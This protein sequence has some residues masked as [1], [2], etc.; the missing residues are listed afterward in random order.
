[1]DLHELVLHMLHDELDCH[2]VLASSR[3]D[4]VSILHG[5][6]NELMEGLQEEQSA[7]V[8]IATAGSVEYQTAGEHSLASQTCCT[9]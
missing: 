8:T 2:A 1:M 5:R 9:V 4:D 3:D 7:A 6:L